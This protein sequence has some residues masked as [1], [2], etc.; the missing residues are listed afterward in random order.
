VAPD[1]VVGIEDIAYAVPEGIIETNE[2]LIETHGFDAKFITEKLG[3]EERRKVGP[4]ETVSGL[5][6]R[7]ARTLLEATKTDPASIEFLAVVTQTPDYCLPHV[8]AI[9]QQELGL[10]TSVA[11]FDLGLGCSGYVYGLSLAKAFMASEGLSRGILVTAEAYS[12]LLD[13]GDRATSPLFGDGASATLLSTNPRYLIGKGTFGT[14]GAQHEA[15][16]ARGTGTKPGVREALFMD[17]RA[18]FSFMMSEVPKDV[19]ACLERNNLQLE[20]IDHFVFHQAS[21][22]MLQSVSKRMR[23]DP[24][25]VIIDIADFG[26]TTSSTIPIALKRR[27]LD[28][29]DATNILLSGFGVGLSW[30]STVLTR[31]I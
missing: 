3:I 18:I 21:K 12:R 7:A 24:A 17:G 23:L 4:D 30:A 29:T 11:S 10:P 6:V 8:G 31:P 16:I 25:K 9:V 26:N 2:A 22:F 28:D 5:S 13:P 15:L 20:Q 19:A 14:N 27:I 1:V